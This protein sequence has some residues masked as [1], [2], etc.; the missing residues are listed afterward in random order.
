[1][2]SERE[3]RAALRD[4]ETVT[5]LVR[6]DDCGRL[7]V[8]PVYEGEATEPCEGETDGITC[9]SLYVERVL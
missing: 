6:C 9:N 5:E 8:R 1:V 7:E 2:R 3:F 4:E